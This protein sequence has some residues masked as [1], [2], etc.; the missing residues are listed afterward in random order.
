[1]TENSPSPKINPGLMK[2]L[3]LAGELPFLVAGGALIGGLIGYALDRWLHTSPYL[4]IVA[5][6]AGFSAAVWDMLRRLQKS[7]PKVPP[8]P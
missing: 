1:M 4:M 6:I 7:S 2:Q 5:G 8:T 3:A